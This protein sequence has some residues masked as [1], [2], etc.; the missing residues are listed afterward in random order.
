MPV[1]EAR[2][3]TE[4]ASRYLVQFCRHAAAMGGGGH[5]RRMH[6]HGTMTRRD[7]QVDAEWSESQGR[8]TF[9]PWGRCTLAADAHSLMVRIEAD[10]ADAL[11]QIRDVITRDFA[12]FSRRDPLIVTWRQPGTPEAARELSEPASKRGVERLPII[13]L[14]AALVLVVALH[15]GLVGAAMANSRWTGIATD[16]VLALIVLKI[17]LVVLTRRG[18]R[19]H[20]TAKGSGK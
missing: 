14:A 7:V 16:I 18:I 9:N 20:R 4:R 3:D 2:I 8:V 15:I 13:A 12:R 1:L 17:A 5:T 6:L 11:Q 19:R 10:D